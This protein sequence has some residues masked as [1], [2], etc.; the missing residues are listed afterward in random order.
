MPLAPGT[1]LGPFEI[2]APLGAGGMGEVYRARD[3]RLGREVAVKALPAG[4]VRDPERVARFEREARLLASLNHPNIA[5]IHGLEE[6]AGD[7]YLVL[8]FVE[9]ETLGARLARGPLPVDEALDVCRQVGAG[10]EAAHEA[11]VVHRD[12]KPGNVML[13]PD[14]TVKVLDFGLAKSGEAERA[15]SEPNLSA[16]PTLTHAATTAGVILGTAAYMSPEQARGRAVDKRS[17]IWSFGCVL[18]ECLTARQAFHGETV[19]DTIASILKTEADTSTLPASTPARVRELLARC[20]CK[21]PRDRLRDIGEARVALAAV[22]TGG[23]AGAASA[24]PPAAPGRGVPLWG[25]AAAAIAFA[26]LALLVANL[27]GPKRAPAPVRRLDLV[28]DD[29][30]MDWF[31][32]PQL[33]P[34]GR[35]I[36]YIARNQIWVRDLD[37]LEPRAITEVAGISPLCWSP[38]S[39]TVVYNDLRKLWGAPV[40]GGAPRVI[41]DVPGTGSVIGASWS[42]GGSLAFS[43]W[44]GGMYRVA[45]EG[46]APALMFDIDAAEMIDFHAPSWLPN[47][48]LLHVVHWKEGTD[49]KGA[50]RIT[51]G[52]FDGTKRIPVP[53]EIVAGNGMPTVAAGQLLFVRR[54]ANAGIWAVPYDVGRRRVTGEAGLVAAG[55]ASIS[56]S[57]DGSLLYMEGGDEEGLHQMVWVDRSGKVLETIGTAHPGLSQVALSPDGRR[58]AFGTISAGNEDIWVHDLVR[59]IDTRITFSGSRE[60][61]PSWIGS[62]RLTY[63]E[64]DSMKSRVYAVNADG[65]GGRSLIASPAGVGRQDAYLAPAGSPALRLTDEG[66][67]RRLRIAAVLADGTLGPPEPF[68]RFQPEPDIGDVRLMPSGR[69]LAYSTNDP[70]Q[71]DVFLTRYPSGEGQWQVSTEGGRQPRW[72]SGSGELFYIGGAGPSRRAVVVVRIDPSQDPPVEASTR[73]FDIDPGLLR[74][75]EMPYDPTPDGTRF[76]MVREYSGARSRPRRMVLVQNWEAS[77][78]SR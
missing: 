15:G 11:G 54:D 51:L 65:S 41:C 46:G 40:G 13:R 33:S 42:R 29:I 19:S 37:Q 36:A 34:D 50:R 73:L 38:D 12:L 22:R 14:G 64:V 16:S 43:V 76:L 53:D 10:V 32:T 35:R 25:A 44:R 30:E 9:G 39:R 26:A 7:R 60:T 6:V 27:A 49:E 24:A 62:N 75:G 66:G 72:A 31:F 70:G 55:A 2:I 77:S 3:T 48:D 61:A 69:L 28:A 68:L 58:I 21:D 67:H 47:G 4:F 5:G 59:R 8:E 17:D 56:V 1:R 74:F 23:D 52:V 18:Y 63:V 20:L 71:P 57:E 78:R 45:A